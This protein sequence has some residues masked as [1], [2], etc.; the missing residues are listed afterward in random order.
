MEV[1]AVRVAASIEASTEEVE[2]AAPVARV[3]RAIGDVPT[4]SAA[5]TTLPGAPPAIGA[6]HRSRRVWVT[7]A[8]TTAEA[9]TTEA[10]RLVVAA[11]AVGGDPCGVVGALTGDTR[12]AEATTEEVQEGDTM[13]EGAAA[14]IEV[15]GHRRPIVAV[16]TAALVAAPSLLVA[17]GDQDPTDPSSSHD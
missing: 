14:S 12:R 15:A 2:E 7:V 13:A 11:A 16:A 5:T 17:T 9:A 3:V 10:V 4:L 8:T 1:V 6:R